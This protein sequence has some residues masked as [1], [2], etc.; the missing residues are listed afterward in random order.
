MEIHLSELQN[1]ELLDMIRMLEDDETN[2]KPAVEK[3]PEDNSITLLRMEIERLREE[4]Q[5]LHDQQQTCADKVRKC[6][7]VSTDLF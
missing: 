2:I 6:F 4:N 1:R 5:K 3:N 7:F